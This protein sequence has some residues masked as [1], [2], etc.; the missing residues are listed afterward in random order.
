[1][2]SATAPGR[3]ESSKPA[4]CR[5]FET[6][7]IERFSRIHPATPFVFWI[8]VYSYLAFRGYENG[9]GLGAGLGLGFLGLFAWTLA[10]YV[11]HRWVFHYVG[12]RLW[13]RRVH[14]VLHG[15]HHDF[16]QDADRLVFPLGA[17]IPLGI[18]FYLLFRAI[19][20]PVLVD[21]LF[22]GF[23][24]G[25]LVYDGTHY[26]IH[27][28]RMSSRWGKWIKRHHMIHHHTGQHAR[29]GVSSP[30]WDYVFRTMKSS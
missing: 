22:A 14:F 15:V 28:F 17:S 26:A 1:M 10:E 8:P 19:V 2:A 7:L 6:P 4:T 30:L 5:M 16:P 24:F 27:H 11:L 20:G 13:Q 9:V 18:T 29:W 3:V 12:P 25:Y 21:P 23:G